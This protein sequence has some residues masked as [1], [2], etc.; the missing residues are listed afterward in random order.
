MAAEVRVW[1]HDVASRELGAVGLRCSRV[2]E[3]GDRVAERMVVVGANAA[4]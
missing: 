3:G 2:F 4:G 1:R